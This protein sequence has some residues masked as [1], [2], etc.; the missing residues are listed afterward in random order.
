MA[1]KLTSE[2]LDPFISLYP[3]LSFERCRLG[4]KRGTGLLTSSWLSFLDGQP[5]SQPTAI[6]GGVI[7][8]DTF[9]RNTI[10]E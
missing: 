3:L 10:E 2:I 6:L 7:S 9:K 8:V 4:A 1:G 5:A